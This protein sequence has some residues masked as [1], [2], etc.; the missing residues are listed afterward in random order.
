MTYGYFPGCSLHATAKEFNQSTQEVCESIGIE[1]EEI[2]DWVC[3]GAT[4]AH[5]TKEDLGIAL[6]ALSIEQAAKQGLLE[7]IAPCAACYNRFKTSQYEIKEHAHIK[8][9]I[10]NIFNEP[11]HDNV[12][13]FHI[14][15]MLRDK[16]SYTK[17][18]EQ[19]TKPLN[20]LKVVSYYGCLLVRPNHIVNFDDEED[21][22]SMDE[23]V[24][25]LGGDAIFWSHKTECCGASHA[26][27]QTDIV[28]ELC[29]NILKAA[30]I[31]GA[32]CIAVACP[33]CHA[34]LDMRQHQINKKFKKNFNIP[35]VY[36]T[37]LTGIA[38]NIAVEK[39]GLTTHF[40][41][42]LPVLEKYQLT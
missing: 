15:E 25:L 22:T 17:L 20:G 9:R 21:P 34:N 10:I 2:N 35:I 31:V 4:P 40:V 30:E 36:I 24:T 32:D 5:T 26:I 14:I 23:L 11:L 3:C 33:L 6:P 42:P 7:V 19:V 18:K 41:N 1:L 13:I 27:P 12:E 16:Y 28:L 29:N 39:L 37:Q 38:L 8:E